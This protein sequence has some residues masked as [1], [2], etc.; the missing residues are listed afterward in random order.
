M[1]LSVADLAD[2]LSDKQKIFAQRYVDTFNATQAAKDAG[3]SEK[4][5]Y[6]IGSDNLRKPNL[7]AYIDK[8]KQ[9]KLDAIG[10]D[11]NFVML[12][13]MKVFQQAVK[14]DPVMR[15]D[16]NEKT[17]VETGEYKFD[18][19]GANRALQLIGEFMG[20]KVDDDNQNEFFAFIMKQANKGESDE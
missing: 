10:L 14:A 5:A 8:I 19:T 2:S 3:Y 7:R 6:N 1:E 13:L 4:T 15:Y 16:R 17:M 12:G 20:I 18:S 9:E 11:K